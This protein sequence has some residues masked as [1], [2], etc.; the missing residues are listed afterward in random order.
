M[1]KRDITSMRGTLD[2][3]KESGELFVVKE[4]VDPVLE[5]SGIQKSFDGGP[6]L[7]FENIK[8]YPGV[9]H[10]ANVCA[11][12]DRIAKIFDVQDHKKLKFKS[13]EAVR[14]PLPPK[15][16]ETAPCQEVVITKNIDLMATLP[17][18]KYTEQ[19]GGRFFGGNNALV[20]GRYFKGGTHVGFHRMAFRGKDFSSMTMTLGGHLE[21]AVLHHKEDKHIPL[22]VNICNPVAITL[23][24]AAGGIYLVL[25]VGC[26]E[27]GIAG[28]LQGSPVEVVKCKTVDALSIAN[29]EWVLEGY[30]DTTQTVWESEEAEERQ[31]ERVAPFFP[32][33]HG[34][35]GY[36]MKTYKFQVTAITH[37]KERPIFFSPQAHS[38]DGINVAK[39]I[40]EACFL[41]VAERMR[42]GFVVD[43]NVLDGHKGW[44]GV[45]FQVKKK[46]R[47][48]EGYQTN[49][50]ANAL[51]AAPGVG[52][53]VVVDDDVD[54]YSAEDV[55]W[56]I[57]HRVNSETGIIRSASRRGLG[58]LPEEWAGM[59]S[60]REVSFG[61][62]LGF[63]ATIPPRFKPLFT[64]PKHPV[65]KVDLRKWF[66]DKEI[67]AGRAMQCDY[68]KVL[69]KRGS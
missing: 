10:I 52:M 56:A 63:D 40:R 59:K 65:D 47:R 58:Y 64:Q 5:I 28:A 6:A 38:Y 24:A 60:W 55:I 66:S 51:A 67:A 26:D 9:R 54:I 42:P 45:V 41:E 19:D 37:R 25:P 12:M 68:A 61:G 33:Y 2:F 36:A 8:G 1:G 11:T 57:T 4:E 39:P 35:M 69:A 29:A 13:L 7:L 16:V 20:S 15:L 31:A 14:H 44:D 17:V 22:T 34:A 46:S 3:L 27:V 50:I 32:E 23:M 49:L 18:L 21:Y 48:D 62:G 43:V 30:I 53:V